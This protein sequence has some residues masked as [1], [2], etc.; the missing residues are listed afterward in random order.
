MAKHSFQTPVLPVSVESRPTS[1]I[2]REKSP[3]LSSATATKTAPASTY[4]PISLRFT[5][6]RPRSVIT[7]IPA[8]K[9]TREV[10]ELAFCNSHQIMHRKVRFRT[11]SFR[12]N[13]LLLE[14]R[15]FSKSQK[16]NNPKT[17]QLQPSIFLSIVTPVLAV[18]PVHSS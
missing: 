17:K 18:P 7:S 5:N 6:R 4:V 15:I 14:R 8:T 3:K 9:A 12:L 13:L 16:K 11:S 2:K 10:A 1:S